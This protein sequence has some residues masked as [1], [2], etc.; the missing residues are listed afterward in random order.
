MKN[1]QKIF[2]QN[3]PALIAENLS[4]P[5]VTFLKKI[6]NRLLYRIQCFEQ[7]HNRPVLLQTSYIYDPATKQWEPY[8]KW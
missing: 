1:Y 8:D 5:R 7:G 3:N 2:T 6:G 4:Q